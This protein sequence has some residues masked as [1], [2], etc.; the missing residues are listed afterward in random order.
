MPASVVHQD[1][2]VT[3]FRDLNPVAPVHILLV[4]R[5]HIS[6]TNALGRDSDALVG[7]LIR[8]ASTVA[9]REGVRESGYRLVTN[10]GRDAGQAVQHLHI[11]LVAGRPLGWPPG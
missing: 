6:S 2:A 3:A 10:C 5:E 11:H 4:P 9:E 1:E 8:T 7:R